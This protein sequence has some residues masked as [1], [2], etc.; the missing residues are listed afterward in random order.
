MIYGCYSIISEDPKYVYLKSF[1]G[2]SI[3]LFHP[4]SMHCFVRCLIQCF[5][6]SWNQGL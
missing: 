1:S 6:E 4:G 2:Y 3:I 5:H